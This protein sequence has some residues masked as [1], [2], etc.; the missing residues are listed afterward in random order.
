MW[1]RYWLNRVTYHPDYASL[2]DPLFGFAGKGVKKFVFYFVNPNP[3][4]PPQAKR[5]WSSEAM[6]G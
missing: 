5:G 6:T 2:V 1:G 3:L 4:F